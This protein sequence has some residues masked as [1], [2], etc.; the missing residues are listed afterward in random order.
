M[1]PFQF[2]LRRF[3]RRLSFR[4]R[5][6]LCVGFSA[7]S[8]VFPSLSAGSCT[9]IVSRSC[10]S[11][12]SFITEIN[13]SSKSVPPRTTVMQVSSPIVETKSNMESR[14]LPNYSSEIVSARTKTCTAPALAI[15]P[16]SSTMFFMAYLIHT[17]VQ[18]I[19]SGP[20]C[21]KP[22]HRLKIQCAWHFA[23]R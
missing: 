3:C 11:A 22:G 21:R 14:L 23:H 5:N 9:R 8:D 13:F 19:R 7:F 4:K 18:R 20:R 15:F 1:I 6:S 10:S 16:K 2:F 17:E 12:A